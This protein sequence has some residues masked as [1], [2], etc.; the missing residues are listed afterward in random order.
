[1]TTSEIIDARERYLHALAPEDL[2]RLPFY[3]ALL[4]RLSNDAIALELLAS[5]RAEQ[6]NPMLVLAVLHWLA[7]GG[8]AELSPIYNAARAGEITNAARA[9]DVVMGTLHRDVDLVR[10]QLHRSTQTNE[11]GRS[12][13]LQAVLAD[14]AHGH[15][16]ISLVEIGSSAGINLHLERF[17]VRD[18]ECD[19]PLSLICRD[20]GRPVERTL[21]PIRRR[22][23]VDPHPLDL[24]HD[25]DQR[26]LRACLWPEERRRHEL[27]D[28][29]VR[30]WSTWEPIE[31][32]RGGAR[33]CW[34]R[35]LASAGDVFTVIV[36]TWTLF[37]FDE[38]DRRWFFEAQR[39]AVARGGVA[40]V[41]VESAT[42]VVPG[43]T[44]SRRAHQ[45]GA[46]RVVVTRE[47]S[48]PETWGWCHPHGRWLERI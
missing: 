31:V 44:E 12:A 19:E 28:Q 29:I 34:D 26:W 17:T 18:A 21:P 1:M 45:S 25:D 27:F 36:N 40:T 47:R 2:A 23:G 20:L 5:V 35:A 3:A 38:D 39:E 16:E 11:P 9:A 30:V 33:E 7:L 6:R 32:H 46:S 24:N 10:E 37:Y 4:Q 13:V 43:L 15:D 42:V 48:R 14:V 8:H 22:V 41:S